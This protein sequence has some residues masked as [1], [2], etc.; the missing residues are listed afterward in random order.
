VLGL[1]GEEVAIREG[2]LWIDGRRQQKTPAE[3]RGQAV[4]VGDLEPLPADAAGVTRFTLSVGKSGQSRGPITD[5]LPYNGALSHRVSPVMDLAIEATVARSSSGT[6]ELR[7]PG[8]QPW[9]AVLDYSTGKAHLYLGE[10]PEDLA[11]FPPGEGDVRLWFGHWDGQCE[12]WAGEQRIL[13]APQPA[14]GLPRGELVG[15]PELLAAGPGVHVGGAR[16]W[17]DLYLTAA[18]DRHGVGLDTWQL[19]P[20]EFFVGGDNQ[21]VSEDSRTWRRPGLPRSAIVGRP[22][23]WPW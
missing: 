20:G 7:L 14:T 5:E 21:A 13:A 15:S 22:T 19:G 6:V 2:D 12:L 16:L 8:P 17:R 3:F 11:P 9:R 10:F 4:L 1:P 18:P 23:R